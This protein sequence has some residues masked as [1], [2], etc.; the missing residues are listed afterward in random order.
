MKKKEERRKPLPF[1]Q[2]AD[3]SLRWGN[4]ICRRQERSGPLLKKIRVFVYRRASD[5]AGIRDRML[6]LRSRVDSLAPATFVAVLQGEIVRLGAGRMSSC[7]G[8]TDGSCMSAARACNA[9]IGEDDAFAFSENTPSFQPRANFSS[10][11]RMPSER[12][13]DAPSSMTPMQCCRM[14]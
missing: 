1:G 3:G 10:F 4:L 8:V 7:C 13:D 2:Y 12:R 11:A 14:G 5:E 9:C 6:I